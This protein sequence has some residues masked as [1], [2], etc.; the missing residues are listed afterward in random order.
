MK[1]FSTVGA[2][3]LPFAAVV[4]AIDFNPDDEASIKAAT[5][6]YAF[7]LMTYYKNNS[8]DTAKQD[9]GIFPKPHYWWEAGAAW[10]GLVEYTQFTGDASYVKTVTQALVANYGP[11]NDILLSWRKDQEVYCS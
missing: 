7:D 4:R 5:K 3:L 6:Q 2:V 11:N 8:T 9:I 10:G 1:F